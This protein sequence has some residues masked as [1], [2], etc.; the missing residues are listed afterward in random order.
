[1][2]YWKVALWHIIFPKTTRKVGHLAAALLCSAVFKEQ[3]KKDQDGTQE[4]TVPRR[5]L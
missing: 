4:I 2:N 5:S 1:M 3:P